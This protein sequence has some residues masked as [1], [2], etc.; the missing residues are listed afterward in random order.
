MPDY[1]ASLCRVKNSVG[2]NA[3]WSRDGDHPRLVLASA[4]LH[5]LVHVLVVAAT[6][7]ALPF[8]PNPY[9]RHIYM[10]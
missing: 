5:V 4:F 9:P 1:A 10:M 6:P 8:V 2:S 7:V 3:T